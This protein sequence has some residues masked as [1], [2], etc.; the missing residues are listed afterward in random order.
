MKGHHNNQKKPMPAAP[1]PMGRGP[2]GD[3]RYHHRQPCIGSGQMVPGEVVRMVCSNEACPFDQ[4]V[5]LT[6]FQQF[7]DYVLMALK[8]APKA[9]GWTPEQ[10]RTNLWTKKGYELVYRACGC[11]CGKGFVRRDMQFLE[12]MILRGDGTPPQPKSQA[13]PQ[14]LPQQQKVAPSGLPLPQPKVL[15]P[16]AG[17]NTQ[18]Y[19][20]SAPLPRAVPIKMDSDSD[21]EGT[22]P[23]C[24]EE[25]DTTD[26]TFLPC[27]CGYQVRSCPTGCGPSRSRPTALASVALRSRLRSFSKL[28]AVTHENPDSAKLRRRCRGSDFTSELLWCAAD[29]SVL[30]QPRQ[31]EHEQPVPCVPYPVRRR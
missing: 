20:P 10:C 14:P 12:P 3:D 7:E 6:T 17:A 27:P 11:N 26:Q 23:L 5:P 19:D 16:N 8:K 24:M 29:V 9:R 2:A 30:L 13:M 31:G 28:A 15:Q 18:G 25:M 1:A 22:C 4:Y 21:D